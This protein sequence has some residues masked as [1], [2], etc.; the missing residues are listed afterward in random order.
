MINLCCISFQN[1]RLTYK[2]KNLKFQEITKIRL[3][4]YKRNQVNISPA[5]F[6]PTY[7]VYGFA[8]MFFPYLFA[9]DFSK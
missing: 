4:S 7:S 6:A 1:V 5:F 9:S 2:I 3:I 8:W